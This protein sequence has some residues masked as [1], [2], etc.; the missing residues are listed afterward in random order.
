MSELCPLCLSQ[1]NGEFARVDERVFFLCRHCDLRFLLRA[2]RLSVDA[3]NERYRLHQNDTEDPGYQNFMRP[4][5]DAVKQ[6]CDSSSKGLDYGCGPSS[7]AVHLLNQSG[8]ELALYD[9]LFFSDLKVLESCYDFIIC[10][11]VAEHFREPVQDFRKLKSVLK[12]NGTLFVMTF[13]WAEPCLFEEWNYLRDF[14]HMSF[15][16]TKTFEWIRKNFGFKKI[17]FLGDRIIV[18]HLNGF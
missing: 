6:T 2:S 8:Y 5:V 9:P 18:L 10:T 14:T 11:E 4:L 12:P 7:V 1:E 16:S 13:L 17:E 15:Y 3:E